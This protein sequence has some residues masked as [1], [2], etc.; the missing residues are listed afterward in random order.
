MLALLSGTFARLNN[1]QQ[2]LLLSCRLGFIIG[3]EGSPSLS[4]ILVY[5]NFYA[6]YDFKLE[7]VSG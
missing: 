3:H 6:L 5:S 2:F 7:M 4:L 1:Y